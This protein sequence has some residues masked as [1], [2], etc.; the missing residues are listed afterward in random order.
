VCSISLFEII[1]CINPPVLSLSLSLSRCF[2]V[3]HAVSEDNDYDV[4]HGEP[5]SFIHIIVS[6]FLR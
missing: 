4:N 6:A 2:E 3:T 5:W 1:A